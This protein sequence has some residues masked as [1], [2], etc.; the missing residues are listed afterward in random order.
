MSDPRVAVIIPCYNQAEY[1]AEAIQSALDQTVPPAE[2]IVI[3]DGS[4]DDTAAVA[5]SFAQVRCV[6]QENQ[7]SAEA[8]NAGFARS[9]SEFVTFLDADDRLLPAALESGARELALH[10]DCAFVFGR[11]RYVITD[12]SVR[13]PPDDRDLN[14]AYRSLLRENIIVMH[15]TVMYRRSAIEAVGGFDRDLKSCEDY[16]LYLRLTRL[17][18]IARHDAVIA[19]YRRHDR[20]KS[21]D[22]ERILRYSTMALRKQRPLVRDDAAMYAAYRDGMRAWQRWFLHRLAARAREAVRERRWLDA[23]RNAWRALRNAPLAAISF[24]LRR[25][26]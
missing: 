12:G 23:A 19:E 16:D 25:A 5:Q 22:P 24:V 2:I 13:Q 17:W 10:P 14:D 9:S 8:R 20:N 3:D 21:S 7:G 1:L 18:P 4:T 26:R 11:Y 6:R 15:A